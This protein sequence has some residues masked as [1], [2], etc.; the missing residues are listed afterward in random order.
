MASDLRF[1][2]SLHQ[3]GDCTACPHTGFLHFG[4]R[5][6]HQR[7]FINL[8]ACSGKIAGTISD[9]TATITCLGNF[10][11]HDAFKAPA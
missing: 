10:E 4:A 6:C 5:D 8:P 2:S 9:S 1:V 3:A 11:P 7:N